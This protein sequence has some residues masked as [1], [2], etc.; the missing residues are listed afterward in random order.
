MVTISV[1]ATHRRV[2]NGDKKFFCYAQGG[3]Q[4]VTGSVSATHRGAPNGDRKFFCYAQGGGP[5]W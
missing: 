3:T 4:I 1:S 2:P 5:K